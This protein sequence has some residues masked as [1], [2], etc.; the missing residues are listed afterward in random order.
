LL[1]QNSDASPHTFTVNSVAD[2][3]GRT[4]SSLI[5]YSVASN[6]I[7]GIQMKQLN[8]WAGAG[9]G[10]TLACNSNLLKFAVLRYAQ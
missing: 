10:I 7:V 3:Y 8:G 9:N 1:V 6:A 5:G 4:D 2:P